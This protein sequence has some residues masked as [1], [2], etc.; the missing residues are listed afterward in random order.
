M[1]A[2]AFGVDLGGTTVKIGLFRTNGEL[3]FKHEI[4]TRKEK[5][6]AFILSDIAKALKKDMADRKI[7]DDDLEGVGIDI[8]GPVIHDS[9]V[10]RAVN[11]GWGVVDVAEELTKLTGIAKVRVGNDANVA[12]LGEMWKG[13]GKGHKNVVMVTLG[14]GVGGGIILNGK[15]ISGVFGA[16]GEIGHMQVNPDE[17]LVCGCGKT[18]HL[19]QYASA[20]GIARVA[21][22]TLDAS[23][24][25]SSLRSV[26]NP[27]ARDVFDAAKEGDYVALQIVS[28]VCRVLGRALAAVSCVVDPEVYVIGGG[29]SKAGD[30][31]IDTLR[32]YYVQSAFHA[33]EGT[34]IVLA[35]LGNDA[36]M[37][38]AV[39]MVLD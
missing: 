18:G 32:K 3:V 30:I 35:E 1:K 10:N 17:T 37:Y 26:E 7:A 20:T 2:Y 5:D 19:E 9:I 16:A 8:P 11:L 23:D 24:E 31:L 15:I 28:R 4:P 25:P 33:S 38:G 29:V 13:G 12:A 34:K 21:K 36:G 22:E 14:T 27:S 39:K 6:G